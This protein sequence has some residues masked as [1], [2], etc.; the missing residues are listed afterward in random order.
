MSES[1]PERSTL[2]RTDEMNSPLSQPHAPH[3]GTVPVENADLTIPV[4][5][6]GCQILQSRS[7]S[8]RAPS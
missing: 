3:P 7:L 5:T 4:R 8:V 2:D 1:S 6:G